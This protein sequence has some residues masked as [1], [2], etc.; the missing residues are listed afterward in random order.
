MATVSLHDFVKVASDRATGKGMARVTKVDQMY[1]EAEIVYDDGTT[2]R[3]FTA[4]LFKDAE[5]GRRRQA[6]MAE[7][8]S[9]IGVKK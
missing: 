5:T 3:L 4:L 6:F 2:Q 1:A 9:K 7:R 8:A